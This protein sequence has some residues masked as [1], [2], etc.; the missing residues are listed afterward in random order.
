MCVCVCV[1]V[2]V[3]QSVES[4]HDVIASAALWIEQV[5][6]HPH[7]TSVVVRSEAH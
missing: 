6:M 5:Q 3:A 2:C 7:V 4:R 1:C